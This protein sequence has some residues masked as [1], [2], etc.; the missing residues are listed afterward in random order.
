MSVLLVLLAGGL[1]PRPAAAWELLGQRFDHTHLTYAFYNH[2]NTGSPFPSQYM[3]NVRLAMSDWY[4]TP[5]PIYLR[6]VSY[7]TTADIHVWGWYGDG[8]DNRAGIGGCAIV[9]GNNNS[10]CIIADL[11][12]NLNGWTLTAQNCSNCAQANEHVAMHE[13]GHTLGLDHSCVDGAVMSGPAPRCPNHAYGDAVMTSASQDD[14]DGVNYLYPTSS[15]QYADDGQGCVPQPSGPSP[16][17]P[18]GNGGLKKKLHEAGQTVGKATGLAGLENK[19]VP[20]PSVI[21]RYRPC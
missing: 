19:Q 13:G 12:I 7:G 21:D 14:I 11:A 5:T 9:D 20:M 18:T 6:E 16:Q 17:G 2:P 15:G 1:T 10:R 3:E 8:N 4:R